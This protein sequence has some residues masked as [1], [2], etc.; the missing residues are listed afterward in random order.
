MSFW[1]ILTDGRKRHP[2]LSARVSG[3][4]TPM[5]QSP[6]A[7]KPLIGESLGSTY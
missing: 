5:L 4:T 2:L 6:R 1:H 3:L 7:E